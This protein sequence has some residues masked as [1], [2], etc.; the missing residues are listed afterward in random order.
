M[1]MLI[2][3]LHTDGL[4]EKTA[5]ALYPA[6][7]APHADAFRAFPD[8]IAVQT[9][10]A[11]NVLLR[12]A[13]ARAL[14]VPMRDVTTDRLPSGQPTLPGTG[15][16]CS[17]SHTDGLC[18]CAVSDAPVGID[19]ELLREAP[20]RVAKRVFSAGEQQSIAAADDADRAFFEIWTKRESAV[21][22]TGAGLRDIRAAIPPQ[23]RTETFLLHGA[24][25]VSVS[26]FTE[27]S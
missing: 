10:L 16:F 14:G 20:M 17:V 9:S 21:K 4:S 25:C 11:G 15:L 13:A 24:Y 18:V 27:S 1:N 19:A 7:D 22:L 23:I 5:R 2:F 12:Y 6:A 3:A 8:R 26:T